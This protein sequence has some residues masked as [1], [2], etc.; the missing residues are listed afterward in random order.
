[1][2]VFRR[3]VEVGRVVLINFGPHEGKLATIIDVVDQNRVSLAQ[4]RTAALVPWLDQLFS[5]VLIVGPA[6]E[7]CQTVPRHVI[8]TRRIALTDFVLPIGRGAREKKVKAEWTKADIAAKWTA[9]SWGQ[10]LARQ[11]A[12]TEMSDLDRFKAMLSKKAAAKKVRAALGK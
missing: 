10:K 11:A 2:T 3:Y 5:Q 4:A 1:M 9:S 8:N 6:A 7:E 12:A